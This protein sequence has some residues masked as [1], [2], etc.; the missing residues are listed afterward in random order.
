MKK[1]MSVLMSVIFFMSMFV[2]SAFA[3]EERTQEEI[4]AGF[5]FSTVYL[6]IKNEY[7]FEEYTPEKLGSELI[8][9]VIHVNSFRPD[10]NNYNKDE[11][12][13]FLEVTLKPE[14]RT[15][16][17]ILKLHGHFKTCEYVK[18]FHIASLFHSIPFFPEEAS[19]IPEFRGYYRPFVSPDNELYTNAGKT[20]INNPYYKENYNGLL[21]HCLAI[22]NQFGDYIKDVDYIDYYADNCLKNNV[23]YV[24]LIFDHSV[25]LPEYAGARK[26]HI[27][28]V[29]KRYLNEDDILYVCDD[30][31]AAVVEIRE[32]NKNVLKKMEELVF[33]GDAFFT[34]GFA[35]PAVVGT[36]T[37]GNVEGGQADGWDADGNPLN[38]HKVSATDARLI[39]RCA[40]NIEKPEKDLKR[41]YYCADMDF[42]GSITAADARLA[43]RTSAGLEKQYEITFGYTSDW[44]DFMGPSVDWY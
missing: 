16:D 37:L 22:Y 21:E 5:S 18:K 7:S 25:V 31:F 20:M 8:E 17:N 14:Y 2:F 44:Y 11:W 34:V 15:K 28:S 35:S 26:D 43:L 41:F 1:F 36:F 33:V 24:T 12:E 27:M 23:N 40:A 6:T 42:D 30:D 13:L 39:L 29:M 32:D 3:K 10:D 9:S 38:P 19:Q 4:Q